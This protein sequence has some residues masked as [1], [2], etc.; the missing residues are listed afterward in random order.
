LRRS[1]KRTAATN[2]P[3]S[4]WDD[5]LPAWTRK[6]VRSWSLAFHLLPFALE[7]I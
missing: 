1:D 7:V 6:T 4:H 3:Y 2:I 5:S